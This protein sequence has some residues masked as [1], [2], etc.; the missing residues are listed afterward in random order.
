[1]DHVP[2][3]REG[4]SDS[5][6]SPLD[7][8]GGPSGPVLN[9]VD[10]FCRRLERLGEVM[11]EAA[12][13]VYLVCAFFITF[14]VVG[15]RYIGVSSQGTTEISGYLLAFAISWAL[16][17][18]LT[19][20]GH[21]RVDVLVMRLPV[22]MRAYFHALALAF[23]AVLAILISLR[24]WSV[25]RESWE[26]RAT[27]TSALSIPLVIPQVPWAFGLTVFA[28]LVVVVLL[29]AVLLLLLGRQE[30]VDRMVVSRSLEEEA[31]EALAAA[32]YGPG[33]PGRPGMAPGPAGPSARAGTP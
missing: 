25:V 18:A 26:F 13:W 6:R 10:S 12:G 32:G 4:P 3:A 20:R 23:L 14:D 31:E 15:R 9:R 1:V 7:I 11:A 19:M 30:A 29:R 27:D 8:P 5:V 21:I 16:A 24:A 33:R 22:R 28:L 17:H 2:D